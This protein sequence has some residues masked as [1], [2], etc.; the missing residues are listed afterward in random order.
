PPPPPP[1]PPPPPP[2]PPP[3]CPMDTWGN[4]TN[5]GCLV[6]CNNFGIC[7]G[8]GCGFHGV[9]LGC[10]SPNC[11]PGNRE[12]WYTLDPP[13][14]RQTRFCEIDP[15]CG[16][17]NPCICSAW[18]ASSCGPSVLCSAYERSLHRTCYNPVTGLDG[19]NVEEACIAD[20]RCF[21]QTNTCSPV[22]Q[23]KGCSIC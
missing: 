9:D 3:S 4:C 8:G 11:P 15:S 14:S 2:P 20:P 16:R 18:A 12:F 10:N 23:I 17:G 22:G 13:C 21:P 19:C 1:T 7:G 5:C 6:G